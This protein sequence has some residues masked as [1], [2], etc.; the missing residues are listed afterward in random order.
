M[1]GPHVTG[2]VLAAGGSRRLGSPKQLLPYGN[3]TLLGASLSVAHD[4]GFD[5][6]IVTL[7]G[8]ADAVRETVS[9]DGAQV[10]T[11]DDFG[12]GCSS[13]LVAALARVHPDSAGIVLLLGDQPG[14]DPATLRRVIGEGPASDILV[15]RYADGI[16]HPFWFSRNMF[17]DLGRLHG[18]KGVWKLLHSGRHP[19]RE[20]PVDGPAPLDVDTW[21]DYRRLLE[22]A[23]S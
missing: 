4:A 20:M 2:I 5:Q 17:G 9:L 14:I 7:G 13:S 3:T 21:E 15:C 19:V 11:V 8:A 1:T 12:T 22:S 16:G 6:L 18:D 23:P 10:V